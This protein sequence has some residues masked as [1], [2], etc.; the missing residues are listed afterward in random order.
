MC[1]RARTNVVTF[2]CSFVFV[3]FISRFFATVSLILNHARKSLFN[4]TNS[5]EAYHQKWLYL[6]YL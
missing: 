1:V 5:E 2:E 6:P 4:V 3:T